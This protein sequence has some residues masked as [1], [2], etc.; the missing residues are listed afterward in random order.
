M[1]WSPGGKSSNIEDRRGSGFGGMAPMGIGGTV[2]LLILSLIFGRDFVGGSSGDPTNQGQ[3]QTQSGE[4]APTNESPEEKREVQFMS[5]VLDSAQAVW[6][7]I[8]PQKLGADYHDAKMVLYREG[9]QT[10]CGVGQTA[11]G[12]FYCPN[13]EKV[14][15]DL[16]FFDELKSRFGAPGEFAQAYVIAHELGHHVQR[17]TGIEQRVRQAQQQNPDQANALS[18]RLE[19]QADCYAGVFGH[20]MQSE[21]ILDPNDVTDGLRAAASVGDDRL[22]RQ[23]RGYVNP[24]SFTHGSSAQREKWFTTGQQTGD[25]SRCD[26]FAR[27]VN[28]G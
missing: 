16:S 21:N 8:T 4:V 13:D 10:A 1:R 22:Q 15:L 11:M 25:P 3:A 28:L 23:S 19:L 9:T 26:T 14:Y 5:F 27:G 17:L 12:P 7:R 24:D 6:A 20:E 18:V 2:V